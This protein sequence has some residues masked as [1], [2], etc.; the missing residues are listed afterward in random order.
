M[1]TAQH[2]GLHK[3]LLFKETRV[4]PG[5]RPEV[6]VT[7]W[8]APLFPGREE[9]AIKQSRLK[10]SAIRTSVEGGKCGLSSVPSFLT[11]PGLLLSL[12]QMQCQEA[13]VETDAGSKTCRDL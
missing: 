2:Q 4:Y 11:L 6:V 13:G 5:A 8:P 10:L 1:A 3:L 12:S 9:P 7:I